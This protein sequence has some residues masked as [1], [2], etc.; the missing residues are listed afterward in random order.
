LLSGDEEISGGDILGGGVYGW[1]SF[2]L[3]DSLLGIS[4]GL[5]GAVPLAPPNFLETLLGWSSPVAF[6]GFVWDAK[7]LAL[8]TAFTSLRVNAYVP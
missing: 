6:S 1:R 7:V 2:V 3:D 4:G 8:S 5:L